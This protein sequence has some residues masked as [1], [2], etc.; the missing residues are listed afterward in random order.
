MIPLLLPDFVTVKSRMKAAIIL[1]IC[2]SLSE[3][4]FRP[5]PRPTQAPTTTTTTTMAPP[6]TGNCQCGVRGASRIVGGEDAGKGEFPW[7]VALVSNGQSRPFCGGILLSSDT[8]LTAAHCKTSISRFQVVV[9]EHDVSK[10][11]GEQKIS[12]SRWINHPS[13]N[14][15]TQDNDFAIIK[16]G[17]PAVFSEGVSPV[18]LPSASTNY[19]SNVA[20]VTGWGT[21]SSGGSQPNILQKVDVNTMT[22]AKCSGSDTAYSASD[23]TANMICAQDA[24]KDSCQGDS[25][26]PMV[27]KE[28]SYYSIIGVVSWGFGCA[29]ANAPGV[30]SRVTNQLSWINDQISGTVCP[31]P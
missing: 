15:N 14:G 24:G 25:G 28:G 4:C 21:L 29:Q 26:G 7:Q 20:T 12:P 6:V 2:L 11:D 17:S 10:G 31:K 27:T 16:L 3:A 5:P 22:N 18:C 8:V 13:Y 23:I 30:Y 9:G 1:G 19:D